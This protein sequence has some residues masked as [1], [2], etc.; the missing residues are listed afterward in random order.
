MLIIWSAKKEMHNLGRLQEPERRK[1]KMKGQGDEQCNLRNFATW[2]F[3][4]SKTALPIAHYNTCKN[5]K[6]LEDKLKRENFQK[7]N[8]P[9]NKGHKKITKLSN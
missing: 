2:K 5:Q 8:K 9:N 1:K 4:S 7:E 3:P 6:L